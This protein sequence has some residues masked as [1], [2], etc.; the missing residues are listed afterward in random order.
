MNPPVSWH[1]PAISS[2]CLL[3]PLCRSTSSC[4]TVRACSTKEIA[5]PAGEHVVASEV[6]PVHSRVRKHLVAPCIIPP[7]AYP[8]RVDARLLQ[9]V[10]PEGPRPLTGTVLTA[11]E[12]TPGIHNLVR[13]HPL[14]LCVA[15]PRSPPPTH[16]H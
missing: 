15:V 5:N 14:Q 16:V 12:N 9:G 6:M 11:V 13:L 2:D 3:R 4:H 7:C 1:A 10:M 8:E